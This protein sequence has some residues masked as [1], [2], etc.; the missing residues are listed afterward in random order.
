MII[1]STLL[2]NVKNFLN[3]IDSVWLQNKHNLFTTGHGSLSS[4]NS[5]LCFSINSDILRIR[6]QRIENAL[7]AITGHLNIKSMRNKFALVE[8]I[9]K[10]FD[11][12]LISESKLDCIFPLNQFYIAVFKQFRRGRNRF[13]GGLMLYINENI[14][15][16]L[17]N[18]HLKFPTDSFSTSSK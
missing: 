3:N 14:P 10:D 1:I 15:S 17:L 6:Q 18:E 7:N 2:R 4:E 8:N 9:I 11:I 16:R 12:F 13:G 5:E